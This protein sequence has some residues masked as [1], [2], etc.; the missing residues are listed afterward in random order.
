MKKFFSEFKEFALK[1]SVV[2]MAVGVIIGGAFSKIVSSLVADII[3]PLISL[4]TGKVILSDLKWVIHPAVMD[5]A[6]NVVQAETALAYGSFLQCI[7]D[8]LIIAFSLFVVMRLMMKA[9]KK[10]ESLRKKAEQAAAEEAAGSE[11][12]ENELAILKDIRDLLQKN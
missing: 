12:A 10:M 3:T 7:L 9:H 8:F 6:G 11:P 5:T 2:D 4:A 1:G